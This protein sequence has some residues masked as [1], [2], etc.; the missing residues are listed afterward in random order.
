MKR[1]LFTLL[2]VAIGV[3]IVAGSVWLLMD[4][5][6]QPP[7]LAA[8]V[9]GTASTPQGQLPHAT[10]DLS[11]YP[12]SSASVPG[13]DTG[14]NDI[15]DKFGWPFYSPSTSLQLPAHSLVTVTVHQYDGA[16]TVW[17]PYFAKVHGTV[18][19]T[20]TYNGQDKDGIA[21]AEVAHTFTIHQYPQSTQP[22]FFVSVPMLAVGN[23]AKNEANGYPKAQVVEFSF[24]TGAPG[25][26]IWN[27]EDPC[28]SGYVDFGAVMSERGWMSGTVTVV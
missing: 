14:V 9:V 17:N 19:N 18:G 6:A 27:C 21:P 2:T 13:P 4:R 1:F 8:K 11:I 24:I 26:Y 28:G 16:T 22:Y 12:Q 3:V 10:L 7:V 15:I 25:E 23:N 20:A 5:Q